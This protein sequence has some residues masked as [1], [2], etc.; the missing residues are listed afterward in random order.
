M[1]TDITVI[2]LTK[3]EEANIERCI[4][5]VKGWGE[6]VV[7]LDSGST[8]R[9]IELAEYLGAEVY[10]HEPFENHGKQFNWAH[11]CPVKVGKSFFETVE[12]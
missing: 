11:C 7:V 9:T 6:R 2:I 5:S 4:N 1:K 8:D 3:N 12:T 10:N